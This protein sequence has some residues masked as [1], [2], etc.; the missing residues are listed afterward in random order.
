[1]FKASELRQKEIISLSEGKRLGFAGDIEINMETG[2]IEA[3]VLSTQNR[4]FV[5]FSKD[6]D[7]I[8]KWDKIKKIGTDII[9][10]EI[11]D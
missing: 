8:I 1:M 9:L 11:N 4:F 6:N 5:L 7:L 3:L 10:V 2:F